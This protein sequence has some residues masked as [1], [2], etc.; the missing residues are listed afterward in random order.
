M[1]DRLLNH[2]WPK[3]AAWFLSWALLLL[4]IVMK[5]NLYR[6]D[7]EQLVSKWILPSWRNGVPSPSETLRIK[8][9]LSWCLRH[10]LTDPAIRL[11]TRNNTSE[12]T[13]ERVISEIRSW[14]VSLAPLWSLQKRV[15]GERER[16]AIGGERQRQSI[17][18]L[19]HSLPT[20]QTDSLEVYCHHCVSLTAE[21]QFS[22]YPFSPLSAQ[23]LQPRPPGMSPDFSGEIL[24]LL[25]SVK[26]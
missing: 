12:A 4:L 3:D 18:S 8:Y 26:V 21:S 22:L 23:S 17:H 19:L 7:T 16:G 2:P 1:D 5:Q 10:E 13:G 14:F 6:D 15:W 9:H 20:Q 25:R 24:A 11:V